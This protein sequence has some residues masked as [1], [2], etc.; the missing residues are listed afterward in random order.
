M[1]WT[2][3]QCG[4]THEAK[5]EVNRARSAGSLKRVVRRLTTDDFMTKTQLKQEGKGYG[6]TVNAA[7]TGILLQLDEVPTCHKCELHQIRV[8]LERD[9]AEELRRVLDRL[10][11]CLPEPSNDPSSATG[12][13]RK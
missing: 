6:I 9:E 8:V 12:A 3:E 4:H 11:G 2:C 5:R 1:R 7:G 10:I 13:D